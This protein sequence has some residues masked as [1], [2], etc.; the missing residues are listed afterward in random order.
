MKNIK[1]ITTQ[2]LKAMGYDCIASIENSNRELKI[3]NDELTQRANEAPVTLT[4][5]TKSE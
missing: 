4:P 1:D 3:I 5:E 2:E